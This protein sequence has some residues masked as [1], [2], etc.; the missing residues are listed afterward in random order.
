[1][2]SEGY[3]TDNAGTTASLG[4][5]FDS[6]GRM[7]SL[8]DQLASQQI[9][10][11][12]TYG[13]ANELTQITGAPYYGAWGTET[14]TYNVM[15]QMTSLTSVPQSY[16]TG[17]SMTYNYSPTQN[18]G[19]ITSD[20]NGSYTYDSLNRLATFV[21][22]GA[23]QTFTYDGF[24]NLASIAGTQANTITYNP[25]TNQGYCADANG[26]STEVFVRRWLLW[27]TLTTSKIA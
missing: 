4:F 8:T 16:G 18:N 25:S 24:G 13:P 6:M 10:Q 22:S 3:P 2:T 17:V 21:G 7:Y 15:K 27:V 14:R 23:N 20:T 26:N 9:I 19:K 1:M 5:G 11:S 12:A